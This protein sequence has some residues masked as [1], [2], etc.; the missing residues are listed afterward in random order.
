MNDAKL[1][2]HIVDGVWGYLV[3]VINMLVILSQRMLAQG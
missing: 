3:H 1:C 2:L